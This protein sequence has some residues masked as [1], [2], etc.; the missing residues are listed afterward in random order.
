MFLSIKD[1]FCQRTEL[2]HLEEEGRWV[3]GEAGKHHP[4]AE[5]PFPMGFHHSTRQLIEGADTNSPTIQA[6]STTQALTQAY[7][8]GP[9]S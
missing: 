9:G 2:P 1:Q 7:C 5:L 8:R 3:E 4:I 6:I